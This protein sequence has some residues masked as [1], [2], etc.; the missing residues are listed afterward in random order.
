MAIV[1]S[2]LRGGSNNHE[3]TS[4]EAN[5]VY[6][7]FVSE[8]IVGSISN[9][10]GVAPATGGFAVNA[11][12][13][14]DTT[15]AVS[16]GVA[17]VTGTPTSQNE[18]TFRVKNSASTNLTISSNSSGSTKYD[19]VYIKL[20]AT[21]L[22]TPNTAGDNVATIVASR[23]SSA[24]TDDGT[25]PTYGYPIAVVTV[26]NGFS[27]ITN[28]NIRDIRSQVVLNTGTTNTT[29]GWTAA[30]EAWTVSTGYNS[31]GGEFSITISGDKTSKYSADMLGKIV[32]GTTPPT[33]CADLE[34]GSSQYASKSSPSG[35]AQTDDITCEARVKLE[36]Y[37]GSNMTIMSRINGTTDGWTFYI[38][39]SG[40]LV[41]AGARA[42]DD[43][44]S[45]YGSLELGKWYHVAAA[46]DSS[47]ATGAIYV[48]GVAVMTVFTNNANTAF[49]TPTADF[50]I[51]AGTGGTLFFDG[52]ISDARLWSA[53]RT[54]T[55][56]RDNMHQQL[57]GNETNL[58]GYWKLNG[59]F[60]DS[61]TNGTANNLT[62]QGGAAAT[63]TDNPMNSTEYFKIVSATYSAPNTTLLVRC[64]EGYNIPNLTLSTPYYSTHD[65]PYGFPGRSRI[66]GTVRLL[67]AASTTATSSTQVNGL[68][69][70]GTIPAN[71]RRVRIIWNGGV[72]TNSGANTTILQIWDGTV[73][74]GTQIAQ[75]N[76]NAASGVSDNGVI[77]G[78][79]FAASGSHTW[80][81]SLHTTAGTAS[82][83]AS[84][85]VPDVFT[86][87]TI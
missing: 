75:T 58:I 73:G 41:L 74:S 26:A 27:T 3:T 78:E 33:Q 62:A 8:G 44:I 54:A 69:V 46:I 56:I 39:T 65:S 66:V 84:T 20:D 55:Q 87:E 57:A 48:D 64:A 51:G 71:G 60:T 35:L 81:A 47:G 68:R 80:N 15:V 49:N 32:R 21:N 82:L 76:L 30:G 72:A 7:D 2:I 37:T 14:P 16:A 42:G 31:G 24:A 70:T 77:I 59:D 67:A 22:N 19:W 86:V 6:T 63:S 12:G 4:E 17:Y 13:T 25:P 45:T 61:Q 29:D 85:T 5:G 10:S 79:Y 38:D 18:Q 34:S 28:S 53:V 50:R 43:A 40:R 52:K 11:Q 83:G 23:S 1:T 9:T 36:S